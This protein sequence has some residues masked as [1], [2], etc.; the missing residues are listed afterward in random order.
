MIKI[1]LKKKMGEYS[2]I[3][4]IRRILSRT[5]HRSS[6][7]LFISFGISNGNIRYSKILRLSNGNVYHSTM[8]KDRSIRSFF[9]FSLSLPIFSKIFQYFRM[10]N[11]KYSEYFDII[12]LISFHPNDL[13]KVNQKVKKKKKIEI[14]VYTYKYSK[15]L[16]FSL[17]KMDL[18]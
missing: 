1:S 15:L 7:F 2:T 4:S 14:K 13:L 10:R 16:N 8:D 11:K 5:V 12:T 6:Q 3:G 9:S 18:E 17:S